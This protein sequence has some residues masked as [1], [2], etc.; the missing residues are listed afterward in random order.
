MRPF[1][2]HTPLWLLLLALL[3]VLIGLWVISAKQRQAA[4]TRLVGERSGAE[5][6]VGY[7]V[8][9]MMSWFLTSLAVI[10]IVVALSRPGWNPKTEVLTQSGRDVVFLLDISQSMLA[11]DRVPNRLENAK[12]AIEECVDRLHSQRVGLVVFAGSSSI[13]CPLTRDYDFFQFALTK[14]S[15]DSVDHG[16]TLIGEA[17]LKTC[18]KLL[19]VGMRGFQDVVLITDGGDHEDNSIA[20]LAALNDLDAHLLVVGVGSDTV[21]ARI[22]IV[23]PKTGAR[24]FLT[25][26]KKDVTTLQDSVGL[27]ALSDAALNGVYLNAGARP[28]ALSDL[29]ASYTQHA[30][31]IDYE[32]EVV[33]RY[34]EG[35][36]PFVFAALFLL[37][38]VAPLSD[39]M[40]RLRA[41]LSA[42]C[43]FVL[44]AQPIYG[45]SESPEHA[46]LVSEFA[47]SVEDLEAAPET[48]MDVE[49]AR[50]MSV[51]AQYNEGCATYRVERYEE[52]AEWFFH[53]LQAGV[54]GSLLRDTL[55]NLGN[56]SFSQVSED[57]PEQSGL[58][59]ALLENA[60]AYYRKALD[61][62]PDYRA[63]QINLE[64]ARKRY[65]E[66]DEA[67]R[68]DPQGK[69][70]EDSESG[71]D[72]ESSEGSSEGEEGEG[73][74]GEY[75]EESDQSGEG[76][77]SQ[78]RS[79]TGRM[80]LGDEFVPPPN[81]SPQDLL[82]AEESINRI[83]EQRRRGK[84]SSV[85]KDW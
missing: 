2:F 22:P 40:I 62:D 13:Q 69:S 85:E 52:A 67:D 34:A 56:C 73:E 84:R 63:A 75:G 8:R 57:D 5:R 32:G 33:E 38:I 54:S 1:I 47:H 53:A 10:L 12:L 36:Q 74:E 58:D 50:R 7:R 41:G 15:T 82:D 30:E 48:L 23:A 39:L 28:L 66:L 59:R 80:D 14:V 81:L 42:G 72:D 11:E 29:Y 9:H 17:I 21:P 83:R 77:D 26:N 18:E 19:S 70:G 20:A 16:G 65:A 31:S 27:K 37:L 24:S 3:P 49:G 61:A 76:A 6:Y 60:L 68:E 45:Q 71:E 25:Y 43:L 79:Q 64:L 44:L 51:E 35:Y 55:Y 46:S 78:S 4:L